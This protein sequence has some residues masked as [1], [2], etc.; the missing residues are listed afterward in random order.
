M[1]RSRLGS[2]GGSR[3]GSRSW[4][5]TSFRNLSMARPLFSAPNQIRIS[6]R[7]AKLSR[8]GALSAFDIRHRFTVAY[9]Y[10]LPA[11]IELE[12]SRRRNL[13]SPLLPFCGFTTA[14]RK[15][16]R[17]FGS[18]GPNVLRDPTIA[19]P[20]PDRWFDTSSDQRGGIFCVTWSG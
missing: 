18:D 17:I 10:V 16:R 20:G 12:E 2:I 7:T 6:R 5:R 15:H 8:R 14:T 19:N 3:V 13:A 1:I 11:K 4:W 9:V